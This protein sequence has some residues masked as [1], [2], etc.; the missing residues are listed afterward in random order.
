MYRFFFF[1]V[2]DF[3]DKARKDFEEK[4]AKNP[5]VS[6][7]FQSIFILIANFACLHSRCSHQLSSTGVHTTTSML[8][9]ARINNRQ[10]IARCHS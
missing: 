8:W 7:V 9:G 4:W 2:Q 1:A 5:Q 6:P 10:T 3:L